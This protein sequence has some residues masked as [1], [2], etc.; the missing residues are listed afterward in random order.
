MS[1]VSGGELFYETSLELKFESRILLK[2][3][4]LRR[5]FKNY[6]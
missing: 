1:T 4:Y 3:M 5:Q 6:K 2:D